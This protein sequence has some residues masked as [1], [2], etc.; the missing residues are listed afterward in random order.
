[1]RALQ[2]DIMAQN[3]HNVAKDDLIAIELYIIAA[4]QGQVLAVEK[5]EAVDQVSDLKITSINQCTENSA[6]RSKEN[7]SHHT[8][9]IISTK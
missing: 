5:L 7:E 3:G 1:M 2:H 4:G 6:V 8:G 9:V